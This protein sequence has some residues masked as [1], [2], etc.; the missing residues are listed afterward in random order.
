MTRIQILSIVI[1]II[2][3]CTILVFLLI[4]Q[5]ILQLSD[6]SDTQKSKQIETVTI[7][8]KNLSRFIDLDGILDYGNS[9]PISP[10]DSG[11]LT[12][13]A[14]QGSELKRG[15]VIFRFYKS[16]SDIEKETN[17]QQIASAKAAV[18]AAELALENLKAPAS[19]AQIAS[20]DAAI[21]LATINLVSVQGSIDVAQVSR[22][23][24]RKALCDRAYAINSPDL[25]YLDSICPVN[26]IP[27]TST[28]IKTLTNKMFSFSDDLMIT[29]SNSLLNAHQTYQSALVSHTSAV[30]SLSSARN[31]R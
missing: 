1:A 19:A 25:I 20:A 6:S 14:P 12:Y 11:V 2:V 13:I 29:R 23:I 26:D 16:T 3:G 8:R 17:K 28:T 15:S 4:N 21:T 24:A 18:A 5:G 31:N 22:R 27:V 30:N 9:V 7:E 10:S